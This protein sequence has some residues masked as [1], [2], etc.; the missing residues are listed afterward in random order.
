MDVLAFLEAVNHGRILGQMSQ[1]AQF[2]LRIVAGNDIV[3]A[4]ARDE[5]GADL[6]ALFGPDRYILQIRVGT[7]QA[8]CRCD[9]LVEMGIDAPRFRHDER[10]QAVEIRRNELLQGPEA[11]DFVDHG[12]FVPQGIEDGTVRRIARLGLLDD[13]QL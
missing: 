3:I 4:L 8:A 9:H 6:A 10:F 7:A 11:Q 5:E 13:R 1:E 2:D 12:V